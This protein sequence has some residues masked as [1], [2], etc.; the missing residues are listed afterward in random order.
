MTNAQVL[1]LIAAFLV[2]TVGSFVYYIAT[3]DAAKEESLSIILPQISP[4]EAPHLSQGA[5]T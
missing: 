4:P 1:A 5:T 3:W 2:I